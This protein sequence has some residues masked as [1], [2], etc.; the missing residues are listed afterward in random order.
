[1]CM[2]FLK[3]NVTRCREVCFGSI[4]DVEQRVERYGST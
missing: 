4:A 2:Q 3:L 1:M